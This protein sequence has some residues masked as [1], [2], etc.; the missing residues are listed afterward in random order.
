M[1]LSVLKALSWTYLYFNMY[2]FYLLFLG[3]TGLAALRKEYTHV[4]SYYNIQV[5]LFHAVSWHN[6]RAE[7]ES[8]ELHLLAL[9]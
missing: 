8:N 5:V 9:L 6:S 2:A 4:Q 1:R 3:F 7:V